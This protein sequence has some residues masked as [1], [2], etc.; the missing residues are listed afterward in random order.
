MDSER[1]AKLRSRILELS[2][3]RLDIDLANSEG[4]LL[5]E[6][7]H[8][9]VSN[10]VALLDNTN[11]AEWDDEIKHWVEAFEKSPN[12]SA[13]HYPDE[14]RKLA[15]RLYPKEYFTDTLGPDSYLANEDIPGI[16]STI[17]VN[18][19]DR[20]S[21]L[22]RSEMGPWTEHFIETREK[23]LNALA[24]EKP[25]HTEFVSFKGT[26]ELVG[27]ILSD[28][29][30]GTNHALVLDKIYPQLVGKN[31]AIVGIPHRHMILVKRLDDNPSP[32]L[33]NNM[34]DMIKRMQSNQPGPISN[35]TYH[36]KAGTY[37]II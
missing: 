35:K 7:A 24:Q 16:F 22:T 32:S 2:G 28:E 33:I 27:A 25:N 11:E 9:R 21:T 8:V 36:F 20:I 3:K 15:I 4:V 17:V 34:S 30:T 5:Y 19:P 6:G 31:G 10:L 1:V 26:D 14:I 18:R 13:P 23:L 37:K 29:V 12:G